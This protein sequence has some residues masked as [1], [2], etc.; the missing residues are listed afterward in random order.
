MADSLQNIGVTHLMFY[1]GVCVFYLILIFNSNNNPAIGQYN[2]MIFF[3]ATFIV[4]L[5]LNYA[6]INNPSICKAGNDVNKFTTVLFHTIVPWVFVLAL[7]H[8]L[9]NIFPGWLRIFSN[10]LGMS[11]AY[12]QYGHLLDNKETPITTENQGKGDE[13][14]KLLNKILL[15]KKKIL[16]EID[17][18]GMDDETLHMFY[19]NQLSKISSTIFSN[20]GKMN[21]EDIQFF[22]KTVNPLTNTVKFD[23]MTDITKTE[24]DILSLLKYKNTIGY[25]IWYILLGVISVM[26]STNS[27]IGSNCGSD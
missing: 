27:V 24:H 14:V 22:K 17:I 19:T 16:N 13:Y 1:L 8:L 10:T 11:W 9:I 25:S 26:I 2:F 3:T 7:G 12:Q 23:A 5:G 21:P 20:E 4:Q 15:D 18:I 6:D